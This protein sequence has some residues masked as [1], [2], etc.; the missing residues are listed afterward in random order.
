MGAIAAALILSKEFASPAIPPLNTS[1]WLILAA[2]IAAPLT[3]YL[4]INLGKGPVIASSVVGLLGGLIL[5]KLV[6]DIGTQLGVIVICSSFVGM[7]NQK[8]SPKFWYALVGGLFTGFLF[9]LS[10]PLL[11]GGGGKLG[12]TAFTSIM[13]VGG[14]ANLFK[15]SKK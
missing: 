13:S 8:R 11:G 9:V 4:N 6:P 7:S 15:K 14:L 2:F 5:P 10:S 3:F 1:L 12:T